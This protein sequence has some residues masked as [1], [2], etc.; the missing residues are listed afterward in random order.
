VCPSLDR[1]RAPLEAALGPLGVP[2][3]VDGQVRLGQT[4]YGH[5]LLSLLRYAWL[6]AGRRELYAFMRSPYSGLSR[7][8]VDFLEGRLRG[9]AIQAPERVEEE[10]LKHRGQPLPFLD[11]LRAAPSLLEGVRCL[12]RRMLESAHGLEAPPARLSG[13]PEAAGRARGLAQA[14][15]LARARGGRWRTRKRAH[16][17]DRGRGG[18]TCR[19]PR[20]PP[21]ADAALPDRL[22]PRP[23]GG[24][25]AQA[26]RDLAVPRRG[27]PPP[28][29]GAK[30]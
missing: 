30:P 25:P 4:A 22:R 14:R 24:K 15:R 18:R 6:G 29:R 23:G 19:R 2:Y 21:R 10:T 9:R 28:A 3:A 7:A 16:T 1:W 27:R 17:T 20:P 11:R 13:G 5:A 8:H 12:A 26:H